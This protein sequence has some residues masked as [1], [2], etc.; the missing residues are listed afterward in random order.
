MCLPLGM[1]SSEGPTGLWPEA[2]GWGCW[3]TRQA[4]PHWP[5][6][7]SGTCGLSMNEAWSCRL[8]SAT[9]VFPHTRGQKPHWKNEALTTN[10]LSER[11]EQVIL[12]HL[13]DQQE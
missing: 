5:A 11:V 1:S 10:Q 6:Q 9:M 12:S 4:Q 2:G 3:G 7:G 13:D 8:S